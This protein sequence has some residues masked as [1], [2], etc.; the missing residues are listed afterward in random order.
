M[1][2][3]TDPSQTPALNDISFNAGVSTSGGSIDNT[4]PDTAITI[5]PSA[6]T[7]ST[8]A[9]FGFTSSEANSTF[10]CRLDG[11]AFSSCTSPMSYS[12]LATGTHMFQ[13]RATDLAGNVDATAASYAWT[14]TPSTTLSSF[15]DT[16][17]ADFGAG[18]LDSNTYISQTA[19]GEVILAPAVGSEFS[20][21]AI[22]AG[23]FTMPWGKDGSASVGNGSVN[24]DGALMGAN[25]LYGAGRS[26][27][28]VG[29]FSN[30]AYQHA[31]WGVD[32]TGPPWAIFSTMTGGSLY[33]RSNNGTTVTNSLIPGN[34]LGSLHRYRID[35]NASSVVYSIDG[36]VVATHPVSLT[37]TMR[38]LAIDAIPGGSAMSVDWMRMSPYAASGTFLSRIF[39]A[40]G[41][42]SWGIASWTSTTP[43]GTG[44]AI[45]VRQ[46][47]TSTP[48][49]TWTAFTPLAASGAAIS[50]TS[51]YLQ[52]RAVLT[53][54]DPSQT[55]AV[56]NIIITIQ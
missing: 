9:S 3:T 49:G 22:P 23:W 7:N 17:M 37:G 46:G 38:P 45:S 54:T 16:T 12:S 31:G 11:G 20:G 41:T 43:A 4:P 26:L 6:T 30:V 48:D 39:D 56:N 52:Y 24:L 42:A 40:G 25:N 55:P 10:A 50:G 27:E 13:V 1:L 15:A 32:L 35:W 19:D 8:N 14:I 51:R 21:S 28:F 47:N 44:L 29:T 33:A 5:S 18:T 53:T 2:T 34:W 36:N